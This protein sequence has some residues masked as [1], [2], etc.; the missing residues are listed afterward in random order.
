MKR[1]EAGINDAQTRQ[2]I[3]PDITQLSPSLSPEVKN[4]TNEN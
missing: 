2:N 1:L 4:I 3:E